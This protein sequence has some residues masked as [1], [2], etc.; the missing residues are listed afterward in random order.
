M[1]N[2]TD[3]S[4]VNELHITFL[5]SNGVWT[6]PENKE[7]YEKKLLIVGEQESLLQVERARCMV[8]VFISW[9]QTHDYTLPIVNV[10]WTGRHGALQNIIKKEMDY[11]KNPTDVLVQFS[12]GPSDG[13][14][15]MS[16]KSTR[17][18]SDIS[19]KNLG[20]G[21]VEQDLM[22]DI[23][24]SVNQVLINTIT[25]LS[26]PEAM[27]ERKLY[28]RSNPSIRQLTRKVGSQILEMM[29][30]RLFDRLKEF[31]DEYLRKYILDTWLNASPDTYPPYVKVTGLGSKIGSIRA[32]I[33]HPLEN[34]KVR[35]LIDGPL[36]IE[37]YGFASVG[38][39]G[40][41]KRIMKIR[42]K[43]SSEKLASS[44]TFMGDP[45]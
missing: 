19:F 28:I 45:W 1:S 38:V 41:G 14:L 23:N 33:E 39:C 40:S 24:T 7:V 30:D 35:C 12:S 42:A 10:W 11:R 18:G 26:L 17:G 5:L 2:L 4:D 20:I 6:A 16:A 32:K 43:Y 22:V 8:N 44:L 27:E 34:D 31:D 21:S 29:R 25:E 37:K 13:Y 15:G 3:P 9:A 36:Q